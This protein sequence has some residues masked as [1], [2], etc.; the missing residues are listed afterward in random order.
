MVPSQKGNLLKIKIFK[1]AASQMES[2]KS[3]TFVI[4]KQIKIPSKPK[5]MIH[6]EIIALIY[7]FFNQCIFFV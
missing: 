2:L 3:G 7:I 1:K 6:N 5:I 4:L